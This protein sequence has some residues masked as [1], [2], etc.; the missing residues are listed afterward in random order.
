M[1]SREQMEPERDDYLE[2]PVTAQI[3]QIA[4]A[5]DRLASALSDETRLKA[6]RDEADR[7]MAYTEWTSR[8]L[9]GNPLIVSAVDSHRLIGRLRGDW[10]MIQVSAE[11]REWVRRDVA[12]ICDRL[13]HTARV[14]G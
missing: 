10:A 2:R 8:A 3:E 5:L 7:V 14:A 9:D 1:I 12:E 11:L 6:A 4:A 13:R